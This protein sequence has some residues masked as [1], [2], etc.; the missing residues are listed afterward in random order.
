MYYPDPRFVSLR[1][2]NDS[3]HE[4]P[5]PSPDVLPL[6]ARQFWNAVE[7]QAWEIY[8]EHARDHAIPEKTA[9]KAVRMHFEPNG[10]GWVRKRPELEISY[11]LPNPGDVAWL[12]KMLDYAWITS[13]GELYKRTFEGDPPDLWWNKDQK[14]LYSFPNAHVPEVCMPISPDLE[15]TAHMFKRWAQRDAHCSKVVQVPMARMYPRG[16][17]DSVSYRSDKWH[18]RNPDIVRLKGSSE[19]IHLHGDGVWVWEDTPDLNGTPNAVM[20]R[21]GRLDVVEQGIIH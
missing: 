18:D 17:I 1:I 8:G 6:Q 13:E 12:G 11:I 2:R 3:L 9:W 21:G 7:E 14:T 19:Y 10:R 4:P 16:A 5:N 20:I 15:D